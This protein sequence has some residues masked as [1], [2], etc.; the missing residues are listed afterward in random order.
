M[1][2]ELGIGHRLSCRSIGNVDLKGAGRSLELMGLDWRDPSRF[3]AAVRVRE[4]GQVIALPAQD[5][6]S[7]GR[8]EVLEGMSAND[9][10][11]NLPD[12]AATRQ[13][14][15]WHFE[16]RRRPSGFT[17]RALS[18]QPTR[19]DEQPVPMGDGVPIGPSSIVELAGVMTLEFVAN[20]SGSLPSA[21]ETM[22]IAMPRTVGA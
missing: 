3:P 4:T 7:F 22:H 6:I 9:I 12:P 8:L 1:F 17:L 5:I 2:Q 16:L 13:I 15:R 19:V 18:S 14:S 11:L 20:A 21:D 10:V